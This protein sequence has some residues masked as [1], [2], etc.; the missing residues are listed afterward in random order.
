MCVRK[1]QMW[2][3]GGAY[4]NELHAGVPLSTY[5]LLQGAQGG[6]AQV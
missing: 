4:V 3:S 5:L 6:H 2:C 1:W